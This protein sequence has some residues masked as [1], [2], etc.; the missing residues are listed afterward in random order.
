M[1]QLSQVFGNQ[2]MGVPLILLLQQDRVG[3][4]VTIFCFKKTKGF[5]LQSLTHLIGKYN[6]KIWIV[7]SLFMIVTNR[8]LI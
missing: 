2:S 6:A 4:F 3:L 1:V 5:S 8:I 7:E